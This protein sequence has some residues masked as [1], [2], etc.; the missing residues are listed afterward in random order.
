MSALLDTT[1]ESVKHLGREMELNGLK[2][3]EPSV[4][5]KTTVTEKTQN[6][7]KPSK[8]QN[9]TPKKNTKTVETKKNVQKNQ[10]ERN[11]I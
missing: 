11:Q 4:S 8:T 3:D 9:D 5:T 1:H 6:A 10:F 7:E 2:A